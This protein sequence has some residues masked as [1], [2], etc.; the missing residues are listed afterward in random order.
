MLSPLAD[1]QDPVRRKRYD[2]V[3]QTA[4][5]VGI[6]V[7]VGVGIGVGT[8]VGTIFG[9]AVAIGVAITK[10][11]HCEAIVV[12]LVG[13]RCCRRHHLHQPLASRAG[14]S[15]QQENPEH[16]ERIPDEQD[17][18]RRKRYDQGNH[19]CEVLGHG[20]EAAESA[21]AWDR[22]DKNSGHIDFIPVPNFCLDHLPEWCR[23]SSVL[24]YVIAICALTV[25]LRVSYTSKGRPEGYTFSKDRGSDI[26]HTGTGWVHNVVPG[27]GFCQCPKCC[28]S[29]SPCQTWFLVFIKTACHVVFNTE[30]AQ[31]TKIDFF[32]DDKTSKIETYWGQGVSDKNE[33]SD[34]CTIFFATHNVAL[35]EQ[36]Q[37]CIRRTETQVFR[38]DHSRFFSRWHCSCII[39]S[40]PHGQPK[41]VTLG[42]IKLWP[43]ATLE[44]RKN[45][46]YTTDTCPGS[47]GAPVVVF[48]FMELPELDCET[49]TS[50]PHLPALNG[51]KNRI[52]YGLDDTI[53]T[54]GLTLRICCKSP[55]FY[56]IKKALVAESLGT[57]LPQL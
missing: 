50:H 25:R 24:D 55:S 43:S 11:D 46:V 56:Q 13:S 5:G 49:R 7:A 2:Q 36:L 52:A 17:P 38:P 28:Q 27:E 51:L 22:C 31:S 10:R 32:Y 8:I 30:E 48:E 15:G 19:E 23:S 54:K 21:Y 33:Q 57:F 9:V 20:P 29:S 44:F 34:N 41:H 16:V 6:A 35:A 4:V 53:T 26:L 39:V 47:S 1:E 37:Q 45:F 18:V 12:E 3:E 40:H 14:T 42:K